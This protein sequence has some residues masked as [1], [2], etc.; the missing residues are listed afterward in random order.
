MD[1]HS[2]V[3]S[4]KTRSAKEAYAQTAGTTYH[5]LHQLICGGRRP[6]TALCKELSDASKGKVKLKELR[7]DVWAD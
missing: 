5:Y 7:P 2:Y 6:S 4:L 1:L 3:K